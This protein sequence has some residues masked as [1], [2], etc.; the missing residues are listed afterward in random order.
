MKI[1]KYIPVILIYTCVTAQEFN[2]LPEIVDSN[3]IISYDQF[4]LSYSSNHKQ[5]NW[6]AY[7][8]TQS[9]V[10]KK[11]DRCNCFRIDTNVIGDRAT[12]KDYNGAGF[13]RGHL[14]PAS[15]NNES[16]QT[17]RESFLMS[18]ISP[19]LPTFNRGVWLKLEK[20]V[21]Q[22]A[23]E[24]DTVYVVTGPVFINNLGAINKITIPGYYYKVLL[25]FDGDKIRAIAFL[26]PHIGAVGQL[27]D[28]VVTV[29][30]IETLTG[31]NFFPDIENSVESQ[32]QTRKW[33]L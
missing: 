11:I 30:T 5:A 20:W 4:T 7:E 1:I 3:Q 13:D 14:S 10:N 15:D 23:I 26:L 12:K 17:N 28:Y 21:R 16:E 27:K 6:V 22:K 19:Q 8:L 32:L 31:I 18:N 24:H 29:N 2:Y 25:R 33:G 9:E